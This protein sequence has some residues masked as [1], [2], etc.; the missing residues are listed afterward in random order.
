[1]NKI[2]KYLAALLNKIIWYGIDKNGYINKS[3]K[4]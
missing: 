2:M 3:L 4:N 1:M